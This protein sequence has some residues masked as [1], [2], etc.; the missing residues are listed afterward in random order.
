MLSGF[1][2][3]PCWVP[4]T[5]FYPRKQWS[6]VSLQSALCTV[7]YFLLDHFNASHLHTVLWGGVFPDIPSQYM[8]YCVFLLV[9]QPLISQKLTFTHSL[10]LFSCLKE[11]LQLLPV[12]VRLLALYV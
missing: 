12:S 4:L 1:E 7:Q 8:H 6:A 3:Y 2:L 10:M 11:T 5:V 9:H